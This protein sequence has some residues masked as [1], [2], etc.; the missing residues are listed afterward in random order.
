MKKTVFYIATR[1]PYPVGSGADMM[2][3]QTIEFLKCDFN[4]VVF[5]FEKKN[6]TN[7]CDEYHSIFLS[8]PNMFEVIKNM[9]FRSNKSLQENLFYSKKAQKLID[10]KIAELK[11]DIIICD[12]VRTAQY[13]ENKPLKKLLDMQDLLSKRYKNFYINQY[14]NILGAF[15]KLLPKSII[16]II[17]PFQKYILKYEARSIEKREFELGN[18][19]DYILFV[20]K[21]EVKE[22]KQA[23]NIQKVQNIPQGMKLLNNHFK[24]RDNGNSL[25][26]LGNMKTPQNLASLDFIV[27]E[28]LPIF[29]IENFNYELKVCGGYD[30][31]TLEIVKKHPNVKIL[32][33]VT[34]LKKVF[35]T[36]DICLAPVMFG[37]GIK[38]KVLDALVHQIP[39]V[40]NSIGAEGLAVT[41]QE[42]IIIEDKAEDI[43]HMTIM[44]SK[45][46]K[47]RE[48]LS[49]NGYEFIKNN[50]DYKKLKIKY[51][52]LLTQIMEEK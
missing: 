32:G 16:R 27:Q 51:I 43:A 36:S 30:E 23:S 18:K 7:Q 41:N 2:I 21:N 35:E 33:Y 1:Y 26:F 17:I 34:N 48:K 10:Q 49:K 14:T 31:R 11:P 42:E 5:F 25:L 15:S 20:S 8:F 44:L 29:D 6:N 47:L 22:F 39:V 45:N 28:V 12:M 3:S 24:I 4:L 40:T 19:F 38:T 37:S 13:I 46:V 52:N 9:I 50:H